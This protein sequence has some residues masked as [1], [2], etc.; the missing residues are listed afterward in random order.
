[1]AINVEEILQTKIEKSKHHLKEELTTVRAGKANAALV[2][3]VMV[4][5]LLRLPDST[6][7]PGE[8]F[9]TGSKD[10][11]DLAV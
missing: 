11:D 8:Y 3:R 6:E 5:L 10:A 9:G 7:K 1:M 4:G 2:D